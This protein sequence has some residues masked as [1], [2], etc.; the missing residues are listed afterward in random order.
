[1]RLLINGVAFAFLFV[2]GISAYAEIDGEDTGLIP[3]WC[4]SFK[5]SGHIATDVVFDNS[6][7]NVIPGCAEADEEEIDWTVVPGNEDTDGDGLSNLEDFCPT[8]GNQLP[9]TMVDGCPIRMLTRGWIDIDVFTNDRDNDFVF[10]I[11]D[12]CDGSEINEDRSTL[13]GRMG[14]PEDFWTSQDPDSEGK[15]FCE[16]VSS[17]GYIG[18]IN[19]PREGVQYWLYADKGD[20]SLLVPQ[21]QLLL[22]LGNMTSAELR[23]RCGEVKQPDPID[24]GTGILF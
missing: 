5:Y 13:E 18:W 22:G 17:R 14:C 12:A 10:D 19:R 11:F 8:L 7:G 9:E 16:I 24:I 15:R 2:A 4:Y 23:G 6:P 20:E 1:M 3:T 21:F